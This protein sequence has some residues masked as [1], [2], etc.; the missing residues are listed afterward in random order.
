VAHGSRN[1]VISS[2]AMNRGRPRSNDVI[3]RCPAS[4]LF[5]M[6]LRCRAPTKNSQPVTPL[7]SRS[8]SVCH[9]AECINYGRYLYLVF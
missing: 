4:S 9:Y 1:Y 7:K 5:L 8:L 3:M 2:P 6:T